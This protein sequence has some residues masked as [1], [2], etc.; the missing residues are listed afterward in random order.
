MGNQ[1]KI[2]ARPRNIGTEAFPS[3]PITNDDDFSDDEQ[4]M[5]DDEPMEESKS[6]ILPFVVKLLFGKCPVMDSEEFDVESLEEVD[7]DE[8]YRKIVHSNRTL[9]VTTDSS[10]TLSTCH[11]RESD[12][13][14]APT[15]LSQSELS[16]TELV[17][18]NEH[19][20]HSERGREETGENQAE[21]RK[22]P[23]LIRDLD[24]VYFRKGLSVPRIVKSVDAGE[25][26]TSKEKHVSQWKQ[27]KK[28]RMKEPL[29]CY[30]KEVQQP[31][32]IRTERKESVDEEKAKVRF[33][34]RVVFP[35]D[36]NLKESVVRRDSF[37]SRL[38]RSGASIVLS[39]KSVASRAASIASA[40]KSVKSLPREIEL[41]VD[42]EDSDQSPCHEAFSKGKS[43]RKRAAEPSDISQV[44]LL[45]LTDAYGN[46]GSYTGSF[47]TQLRVPH[48]FGRFEFDK[49][50]RWYN[51]GNFKYGEW[52][53]VGRLS[54]GNGDFFKGDFFC[55]RKHGKGMM[56]FADGRTYVGD[57]KH[58]LMAEG[59]MRYPDGSTYRGSWLEGLRHGQ[60]H[61][62]F[63][64]QC[65]Y[66]GEFRKG[67]ISG[68]GKMMWMDGG[69]YEGEW[70]HGEMHGFG[71][72]ILPNGNLCHEGLW[73]KGQ[74]IRKK[75]CI[76]AM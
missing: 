47:S 53:G 8:T 30:E 21:E 32:T 57:Y 41:S 46:Q 70:E 63:H 67:E 28:E 6:I 59:E 35:A 49:G 55:G 15:N 40:S 48:G 19:D 73:S 51:E 7:S 39:T 11:R 16:E 50:R 9:S 62:E 61:S 17:K 58:G 25:D 14:P 13:R 5:E 1:E 18:T 26:P 4:P 54:D 68:F 71:K 38:S 65:V 42:D 20:K 23:D 22:S 75:G 45:A 36:F 2:D 31:E 52:S 69:Y 56:S 37:N 72:Q 34:A 44:T 66:V 29:K 33:Q 64:D 12:R 3:A 60:G 10:S 27:D 74:P 76:G 43:R 24:S